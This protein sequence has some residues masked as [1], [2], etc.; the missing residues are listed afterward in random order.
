MPN[1]SAATIANI[2]RQ[3]EGKSHARAVISHGTYYVLGIGAAVAAAVAAVLAG[4]K[5]AD[6]GTTIAA[7][8]AALLA[9][10]QTFMQP[11]KRASFHYRQYADYESLSLKAQEMANDDPSA[12][13]VEQL[14]GRL[15]ELRQRTATDLIG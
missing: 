1:D 5:G 13:D 11:L 14:R 15:A 7:A 12:Q 8:V 4:V 10:V 6:T 2:A 9:S 3:E